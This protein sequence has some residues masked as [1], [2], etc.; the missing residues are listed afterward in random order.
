MIGLVLVAHDPLATALVA[1]ARHVFGAFPEHCIALDIVAD[2]EVAE[3]VTHARHIVRALDVG[4]GVIVLTDLFGATPGNVA[5]ELAMP[6]RIEVIAGVNLPMLLRVLTYRA[7]PLAELVEKAM[8]GGASGIMKIAPTPQQNQR[9]FPH[10]PNDPD[11]SGSG[12]S[13]AHGHTRL[14]DQQ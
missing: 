7:L 1:C 10:D 13:D 9:L 14:Q 8:V 11:P 3:R 5:T 2:A 12:G 6:G 4:D